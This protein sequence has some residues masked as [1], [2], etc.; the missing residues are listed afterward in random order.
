MK[1]KGEITFPVNSDLNITEIYNI[2]FKNN[3]PVIPESR[4]IK[5]GYL[6]RV[7]RDYNKNIL[8]YQW[9]KYK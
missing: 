4:K 8:I 5:Y 7:T 2:L 1:Y 9:R 3:Y 6:L